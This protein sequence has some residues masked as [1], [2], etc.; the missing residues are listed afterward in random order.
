MFSRS[1]AFNPRLVRW[2]KDNIYGFLAIHLIA[3]LAVVPWFFSWTGVVLL[4]AGFYVFGVL[5]INLCFHRLLTHRGLVCPLWLER[6]FAFLGVC[7]VQDSP[8]HWVA[9]HRKHHHHADDE[10]DPHSPLVSFLWAHMGWLLVRMESMKRGDTDRTLRQRHHAGSVLWLAGATPQLAKSRAL[11]MDCV[12]HCRLCIRRIL[13]RRSV[14]CD[15]IRLKPVRLGRRAAHGGGV[16]HYVVDQF[17]DPCLG[18][19]ELRN[20]ST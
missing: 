13:G 15:A 16:A 7:C 18:L 2:K 14:R 5:G 12:F 8:P 9:V 17:C 11:L 20:D 6:S 4:L 19:P 10:H 3:A 1:V